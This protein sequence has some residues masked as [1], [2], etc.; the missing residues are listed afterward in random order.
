M[1]SAWGSRLFDKKAKGELSVLRSV[2]SPEKRASS[3]C[4]QKRK[5]KKNVFALLTK[6]TVVA[7]DCLVQEVLLAD[8]EAAVEVVFQAF[9]HRTGERRAARLAF[10]WDVDGAKGEEA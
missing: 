6:Q 3:R 10:L 9:V 8:L 7:A 2:V 5:E 1:P 4:F